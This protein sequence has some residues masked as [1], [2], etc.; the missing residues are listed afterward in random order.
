M[1]Y[2]FVILFT[3]GT[4]IGISQQELKIT[5]QLEDTDEH[6]QINQLKYYVSSIRLMKIDEVTYEESNSYHLI[7]HHDEQSLTISLSLPDKIVF[8]ALTFNI[9][10]D[11]AKNMQ[12]VHGGDLD[13]TKGMYWTWQSGYILSL[14]HI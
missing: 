3:V 9:G 6:I 8:D 11:S 12:G 13:P 7:D 5:F 1:K 14:I 4:L 2:L 10:V